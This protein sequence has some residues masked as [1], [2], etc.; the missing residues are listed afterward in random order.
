MRSTTDTG[1]LTAHVPTVLLTHLEQAPNEKVRSL[2]ATVVFADVS[3]FTRLSERLARAGKEG[4]EQ[5]TDA[6]NA[7][8]SAL[9]AEAY[10]NGASLIKFG[11][12]ALLLWFDGD[13]HPARACTAAVAMRQTLRDLSADRIGAIK[14]GLRISI[15]I[16]SGTYETFLVGGSHSEYLIAGPAA[17]TAVAMESV[18]S[19]GQILVSAATAELLGQK[20][21]GA[22]L[23][24][25][26]LLSRSPDSAPHPRRTLPRAPRDVVARCLSTELRAHLLAAP[27]APE[28]RT[29]IIAFVQFGSLDEVIAEHGAEAAAEKLDQLV[30]VTQE[31]ADRYKVCFLGSDVA[32]DGGKLLLSAGA[33]RAVGDDEER[34]LLTLRHLIEAETD[35]PIRI[36]VNR[37]HVFAGDVGPFYRRTY[38]VMGDA[39]NLTARLSAKAPWR[40]IYATAG[41]LDRSQTRFERT[42]VEPFTVKG[43]SRPVEAWEVG[44]V[45][46][47][48]PPRSA[49]MVMPMLGRDREV[50]ALRRGVD[51]ARSGRGAMIEITGETG[52]G[53][54]RL[55]AEARKLGAQMRP[56]Q[57][58]CEAYTQTVPYAT[59]REP[60]RHL[61]GLTR[62]HGDEIVVQRLR[63]HVGTQRPDLAPWL[64]LLAIAFGVEVPSTR[65]VRDLSAEFR[66]AKLHEVLLSFLAPYFGIPTLMVIEHVH[67]MDAASA[68]L[69]AA[70]AEALASSA[71]LVVV[72]RRDV[73]DGFVRA[74]ANAVGLELGPLS[75]EDALALAEST[76][77]A[78]VLPPHVLDLA[79]E[80]SGGSPEFLLDLL[81]TAAGGSG[82]LPESIEAAAGARIDSLDPG[83]RALVRRAAVLGL[84]F[85]VDRLKEILDPAGNELDEEVWGRLAG[86][87]ERELDGHV[88]FRRPALCEVAYEG[89]PFT[90]RR[91]LHAIVARS[92]EQGHGHDVDDDPAVLSLHFSRAG[93]HARA[94][95][96]A[97][98]GAERAGARFAHADASRLYRRA[99]EAGKADGAASAQLATAWE[100][101]GESLAQVGEQEA[102]ADAFTAARRLSD[103]D[104]IAE[105]RLCFRHGR[106]RERS[107]MTGAVRWMRR[108][109][110]AVEH[111]RGREAR[112]WRARLIAELAWIRQRQRRYRET[113]RLCRE[114][115]KEG[116]AIGELR[117]QARACYTLDW[118]LFELGRP[119]EAT[120]SERALE[121]YRELGDPDHEGNVLNNLGGFA[122]WR[123]SWQEAIELYRKAGAC[124]QRA[125]NAADAAETDAN[126]GEILSDQGRLQEAEN[127]LRRAHRV[128]SSTGHRE[129]ASFAQMLLGRLAARA[130]RAEEGVSL[131]EETAAQMRQVGVG[132]YAELASALVA[133]AEAVAGDPQRG[134][135]TAEGLLESGSPQV[136]LLH[137]AAGICLGRL[138]RAN[139]ARREFELAAAT[140]EE[141]GEAYELAL[142]LDALATFGWLQPGLEAERD[143]IAE[144]LG[145]VRM[146]AIAGHGAENLGL[147]VAL[148]NA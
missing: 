17:S 84:T 100:R 104:P 10:Q 87:F 81:S 53:K 121:I 111:V 91:E 146:P 31:G 15:G 71:W 112:A 127:H 51:D 131:L 43:K 22:P 59:W 83:D 136:A 57:A 122:Y 113:E 105:A 124:R 67:L 116:K 73:H 49:Q 79:V 56:M 28:H 147:A 108:G 82:I 128:W 141:R 133:E 21:L 3:G 88:R 24:P 9:L 1:T 47:A 66:E 135:E 37:G 50:A 89:L 13:D 118:A 125:G 140:A 70:V 61:L 95:K 86:V 96:Y 130:G 39:V 72:T 85:H 97:L 7:C 34:M 26:V 27:A 62:D 144:R 44:H 52:S 114:A 109:L 54:S 55:L 92:L 4:A 16:H 138:G 120:Y 65:E 94:W 35:L 41:V 64:P 74:P 6:I 76:P 40:A 11:G 98:V 20:A 63:E 90:L 75:R 137:R 58:M 8:F 119:D 78:H 68:G 142:T 103:G 143:A 148:A 45:L 38:T 139:E 101:L 18:A 60:L 29:A 123:G 93:D 12:D 48:A 115:L 14:V 36:G 46:G 132:F 110:R 2:D 106:L 99:I 129:G 107:E 42:E 102:A 30:R 33:P 134:L 25:G 32:V 19:A 80:R 5:L 77:E 117:A 145:I 23:G 69:L 126:V